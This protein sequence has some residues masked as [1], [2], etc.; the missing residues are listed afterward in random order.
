M[1]IPIILFRIISLI[2]CIP[3]I[4]ILKIIWETNR[5]W[6]VVPVDYYLFNGIVYF[7]Y[8]IFIILIFWDVLTLI[9]RKG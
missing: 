2:I 3:L 4:T 1:N 7:F 8:I 9:K 6:G 5:T